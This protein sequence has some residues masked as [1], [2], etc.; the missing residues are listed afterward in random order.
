MN[1]FSGGGSERDNELQGGCRQNARNFISGV[2]RERTTIPL[3]LTQEIRHRDLVGGDVV[4][5][6]EGKLVPLDASLEFAGTVEN[7]AEDRGK[8]VA[9]VTTRGAIVVKVTGLSPET[10]SGSRVYALPGIRS[11]FTLEEKGVE[12]GELLAV[13]SVERGMAIVGVRVPSD[14]RRFEMNR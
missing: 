8:Y 4:S 1:T 11:V 9:S 5:L 6:R 10:R 7:V 13:E 2:E 14:T 12:I 3:G